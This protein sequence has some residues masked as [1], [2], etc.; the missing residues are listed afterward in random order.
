M[1]NL[2]II[3]SLIAILLFVATN[4]VMG[5]VRFSPKVG[6]NFSSFKGDN[7]NSDVEGR[8][9]W[10][11]GADLRVGESSLY[12]RPGA[13]FQS[14]TARLI[15]YDANTEFRDETK[16]N[17]LKLPMDV[18]LNLTRAG[19][20]LEVHV[21]GGLVP[22]ILLGVREKNNFYFDK[23]KVKTFN[24]GAN[25]GVDVDVA[26]LTFNLQYEWGLTKFLKEDNNKNNIF[27]IG[28]GF[29]F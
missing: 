24:L 3:K 27:A 4:F 8:M 7:S 19:G 13:Y 17:M 16:I 15:N 1:K 23:D 10:H 11:V 18:G 9:G 21:F 2:K 28:V 14:F 12:F 22:N 20:F 6:L 26:F 5:Q 29:N 25:A